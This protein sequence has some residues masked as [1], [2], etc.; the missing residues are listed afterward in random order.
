M[1][2]GASYA[3]QFVKKFRPY[4]FATDQK[5]SSRIDPCYGDRPAREVLHPECT[6]CE[7]RSMLAV[8]KPSPLRLWG[9]LLTVRRR[10]R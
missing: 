5:P 2:N 8:V 9:F 4:S 7:T 1:R 10:R 3:R 6:G